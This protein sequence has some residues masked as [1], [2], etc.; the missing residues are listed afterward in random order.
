MRFFAGAVLLPV[1]LTVLSAC[2]RP[3]V[4][5]SPN[6]SPAEARADYDDCR[7][8]SAVAVALAPKSQDYDALREKAMDQCMKS[9]GYDVK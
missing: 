4:V 8:Q 7:G 3:P 1:L 6:K 9:K 5:V 2:S